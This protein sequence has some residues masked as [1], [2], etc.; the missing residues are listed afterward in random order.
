MFF[1][2]AGISVSFPL[3]IWKYST[4]TQRVNLELLLQSHLGTLEARNI[5]LSCLTWIHMVS[6]DSA[7]LNSRDR[8]IYYCIGRREVPI[9][10]VCLV[11]L[12]PDSH[13]STWTLLFSRMLIALTFS[14]L[15]ASKP[16]SWHCVND[17]LSE[18]T[19]VSHLTY[20]AAQKEPK[21]FCK[22]T[23][24]D[25]QIRPRAG[26]LQAGLHCSAVCR[27]PLKY[28]GAWRTPGT[29]I[30]WAFLT[31]HTSFTLHMLNSTTCEQPT[32]WGS[33]SRITRKHWSL[34][35]ENKISFKN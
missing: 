20:G 24:S 4:C 1:F 13:K 25:L 29:R 35:G 5:P 17:S 8:Q 34:Q 21:L 19:S 14:D 18:Q 2:L 12:S 7:M 6:P 26:R 10:W 16:A 30:S 31:S 23:S 32:V 3:C 15:A 11:W 33:K 22:E 28:T 27:G 9:C